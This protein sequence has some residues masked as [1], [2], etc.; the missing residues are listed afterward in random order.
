[1]AS[2]LD[3]EFFD[4]DSSS[5]IHRLRLPLRHSQVREINAKTL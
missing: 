1:M 2:I 5:Y 4:N 3:V